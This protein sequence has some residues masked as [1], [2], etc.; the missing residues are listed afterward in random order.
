M[1]LKKYYLI[2]QCFQ[3]PPS[4][5]SDLINLMRILSEKR[6]ISWYRTTGWKLIFCWKIDIRSF[7]IPVL[8]S[9]YGCK[10]LPGK[11]WLETRGKFFSHYNNLPMEVMSSPVLE[12]LTFSWIGCWAI[13]SRWYFVQEKLDQ[14]IIEVTCNLVFYKTKKE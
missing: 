3:L 13:L 9:F 5:N 12:V 6:N 11:Y 2:N 7:F 1:N 4:L 10:L 8:M 14:M